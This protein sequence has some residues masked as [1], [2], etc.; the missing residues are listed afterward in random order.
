MLRI[1]V[2]DAIDSAFKRAQE[3]SNEERD[4]LSMSS[5][6]D[7]CER[8]LWYDFRWATTRDYSGRMHRKMDSGNVTEDRMVEWLRLAGYDVL[9]VNPFARNPKKQFGG[10]WSGILGGHTDG[11]I[12]GGISDHGAFLDDW[13]L[14]EIKCVISA[15]YTY[16]DDNYEVPSG[17]R[18]PIKHPTA[19][20]NA[21]DITGKFWQ[22]K[23]KG[24]QK[25]ERKYYGQMQCYMG[26][27]EEIETASGRP[28]WEKWGLDKPLTRALFVAYNA[29]VEVI[30]AEI[31][32]YDPKWW[33]AAKLRTMRIARATVP[34]D[35]I[36]ATGLYPPC[37]FCVHVEHCQKTDH[38]NVNC[39]TCKHSKLMLA[40][41]KGNFGKRHI[42]LCS[43]HR[44]GCG[45]FTA[46][47][48]YDAMTE[49]IEF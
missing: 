5:I 40:G 35:R 45:D 47:G 19:G 14:L 34:P 43:L 31:V 16:D 12:R 32:E 9:N 28:Y 29:D 37:S 20:G 38:M 8:A 13:H 48:E 39:R 27:S 36:A 7:T 17:N 2:Q 44:S 41:D 42:W 4:R 24:V 6:A 23:R 21:P 15:K 30:H 11:F 33:Q 1:P 46:C 26:L 25:V 3:A 49:K 10:E 22:F 18:D